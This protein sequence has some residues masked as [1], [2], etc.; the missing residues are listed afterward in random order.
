MELLSLDSS[1][2]PLISLNLGLNLGPL[3]NIRELFSVE[4]FKTPNVNIR[5]WMTRFRKIS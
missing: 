1:T 3:V 2:L 4:V 5:S